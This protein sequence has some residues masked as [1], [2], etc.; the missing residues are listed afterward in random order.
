MGPEDPLKTPTNT[1]RAL[2]ATPEEEESA[3]QLRLLR[4]IFIGGKP[5]TD[6]PKGFFM[7][8]KDDLDEGTAGESKDTILNHYETIANLLEA[9]IG[10]EFS[11]LSNA[12]WLSLN[13]T[14][15]AHMI[16]GISR[17]FTG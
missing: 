15:L 1:A 5:P 17:S 7:L 9:G 2:S 16:N 11:P 6:L 13:N 14:I 4:T 10:T 8:D 3:A 12:A